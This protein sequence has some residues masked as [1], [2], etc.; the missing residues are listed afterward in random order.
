M[1][2]LQAFTYISVLLLLV[3]FATNRQ[4]GFESND[5]LVYQSQ[6]SCFNEFD[7]LSRCSKAVG[8]NFISLTT[9]ISFVTSLVSNEFIAFKF[10]SSLFV[11][12]SVFFMVF[13]YSDYRIISLIFLILNVKFVELFTNVLRHGF[14][15]SFICIFFILALS[16]SR[17][18]FF[19]KL[20]ALLSHISAIPVLFLVKNRQS[21]FIILIFIVFMSFVSIFFSDIYPYVNYI[22]SQLFHKIDYYFEYREIFPGRPYTYFHFITIFFLII[23]YGNIKGKYV[24]VSNFVLL[25]SAFGIAVMPIGLAYRYESYLVPFDAVIFPYLVK[26]IF[27]RFSKGVVLCVISLFLVMMIVQAYG[28][29]QLFYGHFY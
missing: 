16:G 21:R 22:D 2:Y 9:I 18:K 3:F 17:I 5:T 14:A 7:S 26:L 28:N 6:Y 20:F 19:S 11:V 27:H 23:Q 1:K 4:G 8:E 29:R 10:I 12:S 13:L 15:V 24:I 25:F